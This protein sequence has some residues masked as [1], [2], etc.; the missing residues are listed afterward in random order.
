MGD[1][2]PAVIGAFTTNLSGSAGPF[3]S[4]LPSNWFGL[5]LPLQCGAGIVVGNP[6]D[7]MESASLDIEQFSPGSPTLA[8]GGSTPGHLT[9]SAT[10][11]A[12]DTDAGGSLEVIESFDVDLEPAT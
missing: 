5:V 6:A 3:G 1:G 9:G 10:W 11:L 8:D 4:N 7:V 12:I 2:G